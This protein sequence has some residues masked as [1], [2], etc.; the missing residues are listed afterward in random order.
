MFSFV[1]AGIINN[2][3]QLCIINNNY[4]SSYSQTGLLLLLI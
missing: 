2:C 4:N 1:S 3:L